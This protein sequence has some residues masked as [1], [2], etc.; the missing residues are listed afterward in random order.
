MVTVCWI[1]TM[2]M[3]VQMKVF[4]KSERDITL[5]GSKADIKTIIAAINLAADTSIATL[6]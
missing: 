3:Q 6:A 4:K 5:V 1:F 2:L